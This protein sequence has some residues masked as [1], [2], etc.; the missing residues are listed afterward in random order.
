MSEQEFGPLFELMQ[1]YRIILEKT[2]FEV[3]EHYEGKIDQLYAEISMKKLTPGDLELLPKIREMHEEIIHL[4][5]S[6]KDS[7]GQEI[8]MLQKRK[9]MTQD[10]GKSYN[11]YDV[12]AFFVDFKK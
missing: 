8:I 2:S 9:R 7:L 10:Y 12:D 4:I 6:E 1:I 3:Y 5:K 11:A